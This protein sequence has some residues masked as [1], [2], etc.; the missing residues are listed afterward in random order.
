MCQNL[1]ARDSNGIILL[2]SEVKLTEPHKSESKRLGQEQCGPDLTFAV[3]C[4]H[5][6]STET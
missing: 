3:C 4:G 6:A 1:L 5:G 2:K